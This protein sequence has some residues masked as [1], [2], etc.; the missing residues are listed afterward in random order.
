MELG[1]FGD[2]KGVAFKMPF[3]PQTPERK[4]KAHAE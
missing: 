3:S 2:T 4:Q 1:L